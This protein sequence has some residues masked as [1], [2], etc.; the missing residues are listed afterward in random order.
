MIELKN[1]FN[2][3]VENSAE[4]SKKEKLGKLLFFDES[5]SS[6][7]GQSCATCHD[8]EIAFADPEYELPVSKG[9]I[10]GLY[11]NRNDMTVSYSAFVPPLHW[12]EEE[13]VLL[14]PFSFVL[15]FC[16]I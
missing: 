16:L 8:P 9:V 10:P 7:E 3:T 13:E 6:P 5:L 1:G 4:L 14:S 11:G 2:S 15:C 12:D